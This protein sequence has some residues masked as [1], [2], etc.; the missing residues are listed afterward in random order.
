MWRAE[1]H[2]QALEGGKGLPAKQGFPAA[3]TSS[4][5]HKHT[6]VNHKYKNIYFYGVNSQIGLNCFQHKE[7]ALI[8]VTC[9]A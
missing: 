8:C 4:C 3:T 2:D 7:I 6:T 1:L 5:K 9:N